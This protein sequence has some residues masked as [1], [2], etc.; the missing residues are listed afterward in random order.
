[1]ASFVYDK[2]NAISGATNIL[3]AKSTIKTDP[4]VIFFFLYLAK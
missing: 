3:S 1:M 4:M 2:K